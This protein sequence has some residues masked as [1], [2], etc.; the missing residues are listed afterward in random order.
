MA[1][2]LSVVVPLVCVLIIQLRR[3]KREEAERRL[4]E[5]RARGAGNA[6]DGGESGT[7][8]SPPTYEQLFGPDHVPVVPVIHSRHNSLD[9]LIEE[10]ETGTAR[11]ADSTSNPPSSSSASSSSTGGISPIAVAS[12][13][14]SSSE[15]TTATVRALGG[16]PHSNL[17]FTGSAASVLSETDSVTQPGGEARGQGADPNLSESEGYVSAP[18]DGVPVASP[19]R[20]ERQDSVETVSVD[21][22]NT[23]S[24]DSGMG[25]HCSTP[26]SPSLSS[27]SSSSVQATTS[28]ATSRTTSRTS[29][30]SSSSSSTRASR[31]PTSSSDLPPPPEYSPPPPPPPLPLTPPPPFTSEAGETSG[32]FRLH[33]IQRRYPNMHLSIQDFVATLRG[34]QE[35]ERQRRQL[36]ARQQLQEQ[37][38]TYGDTPPP[39]YQEALRILAKARERDGSAPNNK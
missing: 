27:T 4:A 20:R 28:S 7:F 24:L 30:S 25:L 39:T 38:E 21:H 34:Q 29:A 36:Q 16:G 31:R 18:E 26:P 13:T 6:S 15:E 9:M 8:D 33:A 14:S 11:R 10:S 5:E 35:Q 3:A 22:S 12:G 19:H 23:V 32:R 2:G 1:A 37:I 17:T